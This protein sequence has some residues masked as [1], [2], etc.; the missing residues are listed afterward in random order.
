MA[1]SPVKQL[2]LPTNAQK[3]VLFTKKIC[4]SFCAEK[5]RGFTENGVEDPTMIIVT[6]IIKR[7]PI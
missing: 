4:S 5:Q 2:L 7:L 1:D 6:K 3:E